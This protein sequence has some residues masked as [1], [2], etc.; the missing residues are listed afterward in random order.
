MDLTGPLIDS[1]GYK[2]ILTFMDH[3]P[4]R[5]KLALSDQKNLMKW[6]EGYFQYTVGKEHLYK[7]FVIMELNSPT[8]Y[9]R[10]YIS[11]RL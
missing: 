8:I 10:C 1:E 2:Y 11:L 5:W 7:L 3:L 9:L 6:L 4:N